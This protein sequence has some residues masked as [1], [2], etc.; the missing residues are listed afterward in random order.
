MSD[1]KKLD[2]SAITAQMNSKAEDGDF[3]DAL[4]EDDDEGVT[5]EFKVTEEELAIIRADLATE[6]PDDFQYLSD[7]YILSV[8]SKPYSKD[9]TK[10]RP[11]DILKKSLRI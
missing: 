1:R 6:F 3:K 8:A 7:A 10:R 2:E 9:P 4:K 5:G 11:L